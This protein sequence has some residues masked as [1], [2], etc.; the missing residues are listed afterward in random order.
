MIKKSADR[1]NILQVYCNLKDHINNII[2]QLFKRNIIVLKT[3]R[4]LAYLANYLLL[5]LGKLRSISRPL[6]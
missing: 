6:I 3:P 4:E 2:N 5:S 1:F